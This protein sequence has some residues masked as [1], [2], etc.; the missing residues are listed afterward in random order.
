MTGVE[1]RSVSRN[2]LFLLA[3]IRIEQE[4]EAHR[5]KVRNL[6]DGG[7]MGEGS[8]RVKRGNRLQIELRNVP[9]V[10][11]TVA[12]V[13]DNRFGVAFDEEIDLLTAR[14]AP[15]TTDNPDSTVD[16]SWLHRAPEPPSPQSLRKV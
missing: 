4:E 8:L 2:S 1:T 13:H 10:M 9:R 16:R 14:Q 6:S 5:V 3:N 15:Q 12:W 7:M 11:G